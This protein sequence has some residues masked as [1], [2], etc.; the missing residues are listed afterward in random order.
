MKKRG[1]CLKC[2]KSDLLLV[3]M[4]R[5]SDR[6]KALYLGVWKSAA[7]DHFVCA[8][9]GFVEQYVSDEDLPK[10][11]KFWETSNAR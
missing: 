6:Y 7:V 5:W 3:P 4:T 10:V 8:S 1:Q 9:C 2:G 11:R